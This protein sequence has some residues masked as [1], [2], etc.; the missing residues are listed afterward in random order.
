MLLLLLLEEEEE[1]EGEGG[2]KRCW[3]QGTPTGAMQSP[4]YLKPC[5]K[6][7]RGCLSCAFAPVGNSPTHAPT[8]PPTTHSSS[9]E[10]PRSPPLN[11]NP[12]THPPTYPPT[13][14][15]TSQA[16]NT[17]SASLLISSKGSSIPPPA[18]TLIG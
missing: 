18:R 11:P 4:I 8:H 17:A 7:E 2:R 13:H 16:R 3:T 9:F 10:P 14:P 5:S 15:P 1:E 6:R 12:P